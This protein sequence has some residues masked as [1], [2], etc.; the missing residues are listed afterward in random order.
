MDA[1]HK[2]ETADATRVERTSDREMVVTR[3]FKGPARL[4]FQAWTT[5]ALLLRWWAPKS[6]GLTF[7][8]C[9]VDART[10]GAY[11]FVFGHASSE[12]PMAFFGKYVEVIPDARLVWT[13]EEGGEGGQVTAVTF[14]EQVGETLVTYH[15]LYA[16]KEAL[17]AAIE[18]GATCG[19]GEALVQLDELLDE[20]G[21]ENG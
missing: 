10:G 1:S 4:V 12:Q 15:D 11:R 20:L 19:S 7:I 21:G 16:S 18:S 8:S 17:D 9:E 6:F 13:N 5:P 2:Q 14:E 3:R